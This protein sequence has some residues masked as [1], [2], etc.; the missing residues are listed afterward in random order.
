M[1][2]VYK[3]LAYP[4]A[5]LAIALVAGALAPKWLFYSNGRP[6]RLG[7]AA[8]HTWAWVVGHGLS[9]ESW[10]GEPKVGT[11]ALETVGRRS[12]KIRSQVVTWVEYEGQRHLVSILGDRS[13]WLR[14]ARAAGGRATVRHGG[15]RPVILKPVPE[16]ERAPILQAYLSRT[17]RDTSIHLGLQP[18]AA[19][20]EFERI[21]PAHPVFRLVDA[22]PA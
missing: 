22:G 13:D 5:A 11:I 1:R 15:R 2:P 19:I 8:G 18:D 14:N 16:G 12:G 7:R 6:T 3:L 10:P 20:D 17:A 4:F 9:P 21:A